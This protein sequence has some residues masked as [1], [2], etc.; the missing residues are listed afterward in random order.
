MDFSNSRA[1]G[2][3]HRCNHK[4]Y[5]D[6]NRIVSC[7]PVF[8]L[9]ESLMTFKLRQIALMHGIKTAYCCGDTTLKN[10]AGKETIWN[11]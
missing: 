7:R 5:N 2:E 3:L 11:F 8:I 1:T 4:I 10:G 6:G 9:S